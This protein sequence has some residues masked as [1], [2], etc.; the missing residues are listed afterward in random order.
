M[1]KTIS[2]VL[3]Q[4][5]AIGLIVLNL[6]RTVFAYDGGDSDVA[7]WAFIGFGVLSYLITII[8]VIV[9]TVFLGSH[10]K[11]Y[12]FYWKKN[13]KSNLEEEMKIKQLKNVSIYTISLIVVIIAILFLYP[14]AKAILFGN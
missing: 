6:S 10:I 2:N 13:Y 7:V 3:V 1:K 4:I 14:M 12:K 5:F 8:A 9:L 11:P